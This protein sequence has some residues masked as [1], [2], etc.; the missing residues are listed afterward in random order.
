M[1]RTDY[2]FFQKKIQL[3]LISILAFLNLWTCSKVNNPAGLDGSVGM[4]LFIADTTRTFDNMNMSPIA[5]ANI[6]VYLKEYDEYHKYRSDQNGCLTLK[7][8]RLGTY[9]I[10]AE[11]NYGGYNRF[12]S[13]EME[14]SIPNTVYADTIYVKIDTLAGIVI[15]ELYYCGAANSGRFY[16]DQYVELYNNSDSVQYLDKLII[17]RV[18]NGHADEET[19]ETFYCYR[20][21]G[22]GA[23][24]PVN[25]GEFVLLAQ[26]ARN[27]IADGI[28]NSIDLSTADWE[29]YDESSNDYDNPAVPNIPRMTKL[30]KEKSNDFYMHLRADEICLIKVEHEDQI[31]VSYE[32]TTGFD[33]S[34]DTHEYFQFPFCCVIDA[35]S[36]NYQNLLPK[37]LPDFIDSGFAGYKM[38]RYSGQSIER[39]APG[40]GAAGYDRND[41]SFDFATLISPT[42]DFQHDMG[43]VIRP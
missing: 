8:L 16:R 30:A 38:D 12:G 43:I 27:Y 41:S 36:Y 25:P 7:D 21:P 24:Y 37:T 4:Q 22:D 1:K 32:T 23:S 19:F 18:R 15:N 5:N 13:L 31:K 26:T 34:S 10:Q 35:V 6:R 17:A 20:F 14:L 39:H 42:P 40:T 3:V 11:K 9:S 28:E 2:F 29:F 33:G